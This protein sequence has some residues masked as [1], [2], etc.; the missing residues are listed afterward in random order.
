M[1]LIGTPQSTDLQRS[2]SRLDGGNY[3]VPA[4]TIVD[5]AGN[6]NS[7]KVTPAAGT[8]SAI[9]TGGTALTIVTGPTNGGYITNPSNASENLY[10]DPVGVPGSTDAEGYGTT[11][12]LVPGQS[13]NIPALAAGSVI[14]ANA[15][16]TGHKIT[17]VVW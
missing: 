12:I 10:I 2:W 15:A 16:T 5:E 9:V 14:K 3:I 6:S 8:A 7:S 11:L 1:A 17:V 13:F 4:V